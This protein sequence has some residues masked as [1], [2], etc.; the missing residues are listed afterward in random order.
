MVRN[1]TP[2]ASFNETIQLLPMF[3][4][5]VVMV[6]WLKKLLAN[7]PQVIANN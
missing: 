2:Y 3:S 5:H 1:C 7:Y 4:S 6:H